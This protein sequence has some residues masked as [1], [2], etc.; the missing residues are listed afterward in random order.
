VYSYFF[1]IREKKFYGLITSDRR[2]STFENVRRK[3]VLDGLKIGTIRQ[4]NY[5]EVIGESKYSDFN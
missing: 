1:L 2:T 4:L 3:I 5:C